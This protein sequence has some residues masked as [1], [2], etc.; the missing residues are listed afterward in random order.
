MNFSALTAKVLGGRLGDLLN[1]FELAIW[2]SLITF[3]GVTLL[4]LGPSSGPTFL[5]TSHIALGAFAVTFGFGYGATF[6]SLYSLPAFIFDLSQLGRI[7]SSLFGIGLLGNALGSAVG[8]VL[9]SRLKSYTV[10]FFLPIV[11]SAL[12]ILALW[13]LKRISRTIAKTQSFSDGFDADFET[14]APILDSQG[15][16]IISTILRRSTTFSDMVDSGLIGASMEIGSFARPQS[17]HD[18]GYFMRQNERFLRSQ[19]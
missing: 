8:G 11:A 16:P 13:W 7:Q 15:L 5:T 10:S 19:T 9:R 4:F 17:F 3:F 1:R 12:N 18:L 14:G 6:N 2:S